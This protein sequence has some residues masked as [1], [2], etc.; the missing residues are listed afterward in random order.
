MKMRRNVMT[1]IA[2]L[3]IGAAVCSMAFAAAP[4]GF[5]GDIGT[6]WDSSS[7]VS[8]IAASQS[9]QAL[10]TAGNAVN[11]SGINDDGLTGNWFYDDASGTASNFGF[12]ALATSE[13]NP[14]G[15]IA[16]VGDWIEFDFDKAYA[17][18]GMW[19]WNNSNPD[20]LLQGIKNVT[21]YASTTG[22]TDPSE[23]T[24][25]F[26]GTVPEETA[27]PT[28]AAPSLKV[29]FGGAQAQFVVMTTGGQT[30][31]YNWS[32]GADQETQINEVR[33]YPV[34]SQIYDLAGKV[35][36][37]SYSGNVDMSPILVELIQNGST[38]QSVTLKNGE[39]FSF[40]QLIGGN[41]TVKV[42]GATRIAKS[43]DVTLNATQ[44]L[45]TI[46][47]Q[48]GD[49]NGDGTIGLLDLAMLKQAWGQHN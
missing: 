17:I 14:R 48:G 12:G 39:S 3:A 19:I 15:G 4:R 24:V 7:L 21:I 2:A 38:V 1:L 20:H 29:P 45:G 32:N 10:L 47:L 35:Q 26:Q 22:G 33:F 25:V 34:G 31:G 36:L 6:G 16:I 8:V 5:I 13:G 27:N 49:V 46:N 43:I 40:V 42:S 28:A 44:D 41:Y 23:W 11:G 37:A 18:Q 30:S 9:G